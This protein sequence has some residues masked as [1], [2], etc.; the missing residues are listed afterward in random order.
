MK[1]CSK[2]GQKKRV[3]LFYKKGN[4]TNSYCKDCFNEYCTNRWIERKKM[5]IEYK[6]G[7]CYMCKGAFP[8]YVYDFHHKDRKTKVWTWTKMRLVSWERTM[9]ELDKC[10]LVCANCHRIAEYE[11]AALS[12]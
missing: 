9:E 12:N 5:A 8:Y 7:K 4:R 2:C 6:G 10:L 3:S 11:A 1:T